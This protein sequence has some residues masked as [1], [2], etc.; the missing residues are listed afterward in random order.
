MLEWDRGDSR[1]AIVTVQGREEGLDRGVV[2][3]EGSRQTEAA[4]SGRMRVESSERGEVGWAAL[5]DSV[6]AV[7]GLACGVLCF[8]HFGWNGCDP[9]GRRLF[10]ELGILQAPQLSISGNRN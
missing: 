9:P 5:G 10:R 6:K 1:E 2:A 4:W 8:L 7:L 3:M